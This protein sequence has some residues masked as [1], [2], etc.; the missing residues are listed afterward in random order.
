MSASEEGKQRGLGIAELAQQ[1]D[2]QD[3]YS[4]SPDAVFGEH[5]PRDNPM[6]QRQLE[7]ELR[8]W[9]EGRT[10]YR[11]AAAKAGEAGKVRGA[12]LRKLVAQWVK[13][14]AACIERLRSEDLLRRRGVRARWLELTAELDAF[15]DMARV[16]LEAIISRAARGAPLKRAALAHGIGKEI[17]LREMVRVWKAKN[18]GLLYAYNERLKK[19]GASDGH[20]AAVLR[21]GF[22]QK[23]AGAVQSEAAAAQPQHVAWTTRERAAVGLIMIRAAEAATGGRIRVRN[24]VLA[25]RSKR[26][27]RH[28]EQSVVVLDEETHAWIGEAFATGEMQS[29]TLRPMLVEPLPWRVGAAGRVTGGYYLDVGGGATGLVIGEHRAARA[30]RKRFRSSKACA[31]KAKPHLEAL[32]YLGRTRWRINKAVLAVALEALSG[33]LDI[34]GMPDAERVRAPLKPRDIETNA[35]ARQRWRQAK[36]RAFEADLAKRGKW[37]AAR[38]TLAEAEALAGEDAFY[39]P[40]HCDFRGRIYPMPSSGLNIQGP[41][42]ARSLLEFAGGQVIGGR[43]ESAVGW[44]AAYVAKMFK[45]AASGKTFAERIAWTRENGPLLRRIAEDPLGNRQEWIAAAD[46]PWLALAAAIEWV[47]YLDTGQGFVTHLP[48]FIDGSANGLQHFAALT[49]DAD[50]A[51]SVNLIGGQDRPQDI[52][53]EVAGQMTEELRRCADEARGDSS[54]KQWLKVFASGEVPRAFAKR[55][56]MTAAYGVT[57]GT[58]M[59]FAG[60]LLNELDPKG[61][62]IAVAGEER[63]EARVWLAKMVRRVLASPSTAMASVQGGRLASAETFMKWLG[64]VTTK[65]SSGTGGMEWTTPSGWPWVL[66]YG[67]MERARVDARFREAEGGPPTRATAWLLEESDTKLS[68]QTQRA[69]A[70]SNFIHGLDASALVFALGIMQERGVSGVGVI[71]D[72]V[73][74]L[75]TEMEAISVAVREGFVMLYAENDP[76]RS[77]YRA[78]RRQAVDPDA[79]AEPPERGAFDVSEVLESRYFFA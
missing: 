16:T 13:P 12:P 37:L 70:P 31:A 30:V 17:E 22:N 43:D 52:Y 58:I 47:R 74:G 60:E 72:C 34:P 61:R 29:S 36:A 15:E 6:L 75:A 21:H 67:R 23:V 8:G 73:G 50:L 53:A 7:D 35:E 65:A 27:S 46:Q 64:A 68:R 32:N 18:P 42:L 39:F 62:V 57:T 41:D 4:I 54:A 69:S 9:L 10:R 3:P 76:V 66:S 44:L 1:P 2:V 49:R 28:N 24:D 38:R 45:A 5:W 55:V 79:I 25:N 33:G 56:V 63:K 19:A 40:H 11:L 77:F 78:A 26:G 14:M 48:V 20:K 71:H 51:V 59:S